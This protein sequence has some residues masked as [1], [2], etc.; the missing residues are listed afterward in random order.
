MSRRTARDIEHDIVR[1]RSEVAATIDALDL[2]LSARRL[3][4]EAWRVVRDGG[5]V[6]QVRRHPVPLALIGAGIGWLLVDTMTGDGRGRMRGST[7]TEAWPPTEAHLTSSRDWSDRDV[8]EFGETMDDGG[9]A[10][11]AVA[12]AR[13]AAGTAAEGAREAGSELAERGREMVDRASDASDRARSGARRA[14]GR[15]ARMVHDNPLAVGGAVAV[16][17]FVIALALPS[18]R[19]QE[20]LPQETDGQSAARAGDAVRAAAASAAA[21][22]RERVG[23]EGDAGRRDLERDDADR[24]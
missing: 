12:A 5:L 1:T 10:G 22:A 24:P 7:D 16:A 8:T 21:A 17:G 2:K 9:S 18:T 15:L 20:E 23:F 13:R 4:D 11:K 19:R 14:G 6:E 3:A